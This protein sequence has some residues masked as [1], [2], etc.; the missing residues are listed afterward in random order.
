[1]G[2]TGLQVSILGMG[3]YHLGAALSQDIVN[4][5]VAKALD[6]GINFFD[7]A[8]EYHGGAGEERLGI[9][10][11]GKREQAILVTGAC[12]YGRA[13]DVAMRMLDESLVRLQTDH[14]DVW[15]VHDVIYYNDP[16]LAYRADGV[17]EALTA[18]K[19]QGKVRFVGFAGHKNPSIHLDMLSRGFHFD[20]V[21][22]PINPFD[23]SF[24]SFEKAVLPVAVQKGM[25]VFSIK[26]MSGA[27]ESIVRGALTPTEA[28]SYAMSVAGV[29]TTVSGMNSMEVLDQNLAIAQ[30]FK[31]LA[32]EQMAALREHGRQFNDGRY[33]L[34]KTTVKYDSDLGRAQ[35]GF[36]SSIEL[37]A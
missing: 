36:P 6:H 27:G 13:K 12:T 26:S 19:Q 33:E 31:P 17:L 1:M 15:Q 20:T 29:S 30:T 18:A 3:G 7:N 2:N 24:R 9:A 14:V 23:P 22:M 34:Y 16:E 25:A 11:K 8:W 32:E 4:D 35:H 28:L 5:M 37:P 21:E 10:L